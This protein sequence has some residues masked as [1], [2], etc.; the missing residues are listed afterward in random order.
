MPFTFDSLTVTAKPLTIRDGNAI[1][2]LAGRAEPSPDGTVYNRAIWFAE[3]VVAG[4]V[5]GGDFPIPRVNEKSTDAEVQASYTA[6]GDLPYQ[7]ST[8]W[9][10][11]MERV[12]KLPNGFPSRT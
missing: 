3:F 10:A 11:E 2:I 6:W 7:F 8:E 1:S 4:Q 5:E 9:R 12:Q